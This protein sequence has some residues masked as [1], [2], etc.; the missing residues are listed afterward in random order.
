MKLLL[1]THIFLWF[2]NNDSRLPY[3]WQTLIEDS[4]I[5]VYLSVVSLWEVILKY[6]LGK[7]DLPESPELYLPK[8]RQR[9]FIQNLD[10]DEPSV[11]Q[12]IKLPSLHR[13]PFDRMLMSQAISYGLTLMT[14]DSAIKAYSV[15]GL[16]L[17]IN[18]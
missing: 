15:E 4:T 12:L 5:E 17:L 16:Y 3:Q 11:T 1:D 9:H 8:Q 14:V 2:I 13:D 10:L 7:L 6:Q 18:S